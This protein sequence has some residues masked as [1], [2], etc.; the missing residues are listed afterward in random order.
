M[1]ITVFYGVLKLR[2]M[3][4]VYDAHCPSKASK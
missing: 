3:Q 1:V 4:A 2:R